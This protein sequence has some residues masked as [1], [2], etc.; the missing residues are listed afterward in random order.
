M[1]YG[2]LMAMFN[3]KM[4]AAVTR[5]GAA[6]AENCGGNAQT[7]RPVTFA[8]KWLVC[9][10]LPLRIR[11][12]SRHQLDCVAELAWAQPTILPLALGSTHPNEN[13]KVIRKRYFNYRAVVLLCVHLF[14]CVD[15][16]AYNAGQGNS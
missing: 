14:L 15:Q 4:V 5:I 2:N 10:R 7:A 8:A 6:A 9:A 1:A 3:L 13:R 11:L 16:C 12:R